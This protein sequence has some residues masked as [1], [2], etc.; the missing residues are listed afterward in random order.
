MLVNFKVEVR[1]KQAGFL[2]EWIENLV[3][4]DM[5]G[6]LRNTGR[7]AMAAFM[8][9]SDAPLHHPPRA[10]RGRPWRIHASALHPLRC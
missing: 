10:V 4:E 5:K 7:A 8:S 6:A 1:L 2:F 9:V 3:D